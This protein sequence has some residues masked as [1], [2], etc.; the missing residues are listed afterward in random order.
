MIVIAAQ[1]L[2]Q[3]LHNFAE[4]KPSNQIGSSGR[5]GRSSGRSRSTSEC[6]ERTASGTPRTRRHNRCRQ[7]PNFGAEKCT[8]LNSPGQMTTPVVVGYDT[9]VPFSCHTMIEFSNI[10]QSKMHPGEFR[11]TSNNVRSE[12]KLASGKV[13]SFPRV[14]NLELGWFPMEQ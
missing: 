13:S 1:H 11:N 5:G 7:H 9:Y 10:A 4:G 12:G 8:A 2:R 14:F 6:G 3:R